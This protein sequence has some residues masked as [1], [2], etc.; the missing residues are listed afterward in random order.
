MADRKPLAVLIAE[1]DELA[2]KATPGPWK[3][4]PSIHGSRYQ[5]VEIDAA[6]NYTTLELKP[7]DALLIAALRSHWPTLRDA[8]ATLERDARRYRW[9]R[10]RNWFDSDL[11]V[12]AMPRVAVKLGHDCPSLDRLDTAID[13][14]LNPAEST[15]EPKP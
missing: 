12:V 11:C 3:A 13:A 4:K 2:A 9:L 10:E 15:Q 7:D 6:E 5:Y 1:I 14:L 8:L